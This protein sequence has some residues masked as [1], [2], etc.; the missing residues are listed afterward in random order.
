MKTNSFVKDRHTVA[1]R[2]L[3][4]YFSIYREFLVVSSVFVLVLERQRCFLTPAA[5]ASLF[6]K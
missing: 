4:F 3:K 2:T 6:V 5:L 1:L